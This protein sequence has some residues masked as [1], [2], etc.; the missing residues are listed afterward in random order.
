VTEHEKSIIRRMRESGATYAAIADHL[1][2]SLNTVKNEVEIQRFLK[3][4]LWMFG[5][6][7]VFIIENGMIN[8]QNI[9]DV[10]PLNYESY[11]DIIEV[12]LPRE[13]LF[14]FDESHDNYYSTA[15]LTKAIAQTQNY[16]FEL[17]KKAVDE[18]YQTKNG[19][20]IIRPKGIILFGSTDTLNEGERRYL[21]IFNSSYHNLHV[22]TYQQL[23]EKA[24]NTLQIWRKGDGHNPSNSS[25]S[26]INTTKR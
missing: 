17:E 23:L 16:I 22:I 6:D 26:D 12:K 11:I 9:L 15:Y 5:N 7:Y 14:N 20:K 1:N 25:D 21:R 10:I 24:Q 13:K 2:L 18:E 4:N 19:C 3:D 8:A